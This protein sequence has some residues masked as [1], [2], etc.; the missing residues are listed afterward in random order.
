M[1][2]LHLEILAATVLL[3]ALIVVPVCMGVNFLRKMTRL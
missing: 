2:E 3:G 1:P